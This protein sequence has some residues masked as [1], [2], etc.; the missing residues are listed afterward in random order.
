MRGGSG[1]EITI[2]CKFRSVADL[3]KGPA[4]LQSGERR[5][6]RCCAHGEYIGIF[7]LAF[8]CERHVFY[9]ICQYVPIYLLMYC[10]LLAGSLSRDSMFVSAHSFWIGS[11]SLQCPS[12]AGSIQWVKYPNKGRFLIWLE[13]SAGIDWSFLLCSAFWICFIKIYSRLL[14]IC[15]LSSGTCT[16]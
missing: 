6:Q 7:R 9:F 12:P 8:N 3:N 1:S 11:W 5:T 14:K 2:I 13:V 4:V 16:F 10:S 15:W